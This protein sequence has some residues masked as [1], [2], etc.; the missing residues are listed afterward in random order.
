ML[1]VYSLAFGGTGVSQWDLIVAL[2][3][4]WRSPVGGAFSSTRLQVVACDVWSFCLL[5]HNEKG[6]LYQN[7][8]VLVEAI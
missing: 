2:A 4:G 7:K 6:V 3:S 8:A 5:E 1:G